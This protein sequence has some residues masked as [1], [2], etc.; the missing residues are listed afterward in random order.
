M[1]IAATLHLQSTNL[2]RPILRNAIRQTRRKRPFTLIAIA[3]LPDHLHL[4]LQ[5]PPDDTDYS[6]RMQKVKERFTKEYLAVGGDE[7]AR[8]TSQI[9]RGERGVW[10]PRFWEHAIRDEKDLKRCA[11]YIHWNPIKHALV[12]RVI[13]YPWSSFH[14]FLRLGVYPEEWGGDNPCPRLDMPL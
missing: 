1:E 14:R 10:Q 2:A 6:G 4:I 3:L 12:S 9:F 13:D 5:L 7:T 8:T 11:D